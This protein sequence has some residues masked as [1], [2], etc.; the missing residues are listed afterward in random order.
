MTHV[1]TPSSNVPKG[2][3]CVFCG[4]PAG[5]REHALPTW[6]AEHLQAGKIPVYPRFFSDTHGWEAQGGARGAGNLITKRVCTSCNCGWMAD[7]EGEVSAIL[8]DLVRVGRSSLD[9]TSLQSL[10]Q[11]EVVIRRWLTKTA[12]T[13]S[14]L[15]SRSGGAQVPEHLA[16]ETKLNT[17]QDTALIYA[18]WIGEPGFN[19]MTNAGFPAFF[20][21]KFSRNFVRKDGRDH[22]HFALQINHLVVRITNAPGGGLILLDPP[23]DGPSYSPCFITERLL[24]V[25]HDDSPIFPDFPS[26]IKACFPL[27]GQGQPTRGALQEA[28][29]SIGR[30]G[31]VP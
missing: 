13:M 6:L 3:E 31:I 11:H 9:R 17:L 20:N 1:T 21:G 5:S 2:R 8:S 10:R 4:G 15:V 26:F 29:E 22:F 23:K 19:S 18:G 25:D 30:P 14:H 7:L 12:I 27:F 16:N 24:E 28:G